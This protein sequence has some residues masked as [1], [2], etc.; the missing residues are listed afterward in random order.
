[1]VSEKITLFTLKE[2][3]WYQYGSARPCFLPV[4]CEPEMRWDFRQHRRFLKNHPE[5]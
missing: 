4:D 2:P 3:F 5:W 1:M